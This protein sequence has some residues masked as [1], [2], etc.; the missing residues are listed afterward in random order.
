MSLS[1]RAARESD[2]PRL[3]H[4]RAAVR[5]NRLQHLAIGPDDYRPFI[6]DARCWVWEE[7]GRVHGFAA[8]DA[9]AASVWAL[10]VDPASEGRGIGRALLERLTRAARQR[11]LSALTLE[12]APGTRAER[13][14]RRAGWEL[15]DRD[16][17]TLRLRRTI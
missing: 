9:D 4:I 3:M 5:E 12:T 16:E 10:F 13:V 2:I 11:G 17:H 6:A 15:A 7:D 8:L 1:V 14:Y